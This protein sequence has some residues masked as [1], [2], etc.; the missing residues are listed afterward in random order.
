MGLDMYLVSV[1]NPDD[2][3]VY[4]AAMA[5]SESAAARFKRTRHRNDFIAMTRNRRGA[6]GSTPWAYSFG[7][8]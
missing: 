2:Q 8:R 4:D 5:A 3:R 6:A 1:F 7:L